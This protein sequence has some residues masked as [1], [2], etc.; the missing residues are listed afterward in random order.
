MGGNVR[1]KKRRDRRG[2][3]VEKKKKRVGQIDANLVLVRECHALVVV[4]KAVAPRGSCDEAELLCLPFIFLFIFGSL[5]L[6]LILMGNNICP[7][8]LIDNVTNRNQIGN[9]CAYVFIAL[10]RSQIT[11]DSGRVLGGGRA[12]AHRSFEQS[13]LTAGI[14]RGKEGS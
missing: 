4:F 9:F 11:L 8:I 3:G 7:S 14:L 2:G 13:L 12:K 6:I 5:I 1:V 10:K